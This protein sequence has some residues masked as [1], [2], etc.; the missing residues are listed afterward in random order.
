VVFTF[1][2]CGIGVESAFAQ[3]SGGVGRRIS[4]KKVSNDLPK[5]MNIGPVYVIGERPVPIF[6]GPG[7]GS[8]EPGP[9]SPPGPAPYDPGYG[10][11]PAPSQPSNPPLPPPP[12]TRTQWEF[13]SCDVDVYSLTAG[14]VEG[15]ARHAVSYYSTRIAYSSSVTVNVGDPDK[16]HGYVCQNG[17]IAGIGKIKT[18]RIV[19]Y[20][21]CGDDNSYHDYPPIYSFDTCSN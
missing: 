2:V 7:A 17:T 10:G 6:D 3:Q 12:T 5:V 1:V 4:K 14:R 15:C 16:P 9:I 8:G 11:A 13:C 20:P 19:D 18:T 21:N